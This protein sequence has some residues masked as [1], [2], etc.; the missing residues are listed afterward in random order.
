[1][2]TIIN[3]P[4][5]GT[6]RT[7]ESGGGAGMLIG[8]I[9]LILVLIIFF[10]YGLP[11]LRGSSNKGNTINVPDKIDVDVNPSSGGTGTAQ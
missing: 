4:D 10:V 7:V 9:V 6:D 5:S 3:N 2:A 8:A 1:M 11:A